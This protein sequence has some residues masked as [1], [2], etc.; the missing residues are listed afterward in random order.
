MTE[1]ILLASHNRKLCA[2]FINLKL[3]LKAM[4]KVQAKHVSRDYG[5][6]NRFCVSLHIMGDQ[7]DNTR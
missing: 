1:A 4:L 3:D 7:F 5:G 6:L 2:I